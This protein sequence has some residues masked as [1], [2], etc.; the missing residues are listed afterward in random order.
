MHLPAPSGFPNR[1]G[2]DGYQGE[3]IPPKS[4]AEEV[5]RV[6]KPVLLSPHPPLV[7][8]PFCFSDLHLLSPP[9]GTSGIPRATPLLGLPFPRF[10]T[11]PGL[12]RTRCQV[13]GPRAP[14]AACRS[15]GSTFTFGLQAKSGGCS[16]T[17]SRV[18]PRPTG[19][20]CAPRGGGCSAGEGFD[21]PVLP[22]P[23]EKARGPRDGEGGA[24]GSCGAARG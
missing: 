8:Q 10:R 19:T 20:R 6:Q 2:A 1:G 9:L 14:R 24:P 18:C 16:A 17:V 13:S 23:P 11:K 4:H 5:I 3:T 7:L 15:L 21:P 22:V 12:P